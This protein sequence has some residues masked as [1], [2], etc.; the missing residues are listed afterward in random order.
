VSQR[1]HD[2]QEAASAVVRAVL[3]ARSSGD[4]E[5]CC[6]DVIGAVMLICGDDP[7]TKCAVAWFMRRAAQRLDGGVIDAMTLQ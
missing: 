4:T 5:Q 1:D 2:V 6:F 7:Q 3:A